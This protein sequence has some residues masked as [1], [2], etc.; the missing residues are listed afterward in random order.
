MLHIDSA[1]YEAIAQA[2][3]A[4]FKRRE[5]DRVR[6]L[7]PA[8]AAA[9]GEPGLVA[10]AD[11]AGLRAERRGYLAEPEIMLWLDLMV[12]LGVAFD[13]DPLLPWAGRFP[14]AAGEGGKRLQELGDRAQDYLAKVAGPGGERLAAALGRFAAAGVDEL[15]VRPVESSDQLAETLARL[16]PEKHQAAGYPAVQAFMQGTIAAGLQAGIRAKDRIVLTI[17]FDYLFGWGATASPVF[18]AALAGPAAAELPVADLLARMQAFARRLAGK[19]S[20]GR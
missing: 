3:R 6:Q 13:D 8:Y 18:Q 11:L 19:P 1:M 7:F 10:L 17:E 4:T 15:V 9:L 5:V 14:E 16:Y 2:M 20:G 12:R